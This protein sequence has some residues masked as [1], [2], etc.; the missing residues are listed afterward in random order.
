[1]LDQIVRTVGAA[2]SGNSTSLWGTIGGALLGGGG[3]IIGQQM[4]NEANARQSHDMI[5][6]QE[7]MSST[8]HQR[9]VADLKAAGLNPI[10]SA[11]GGASTPSGAQAQMENVLEGT[12]AS[13]IELANMKL[14][15][16]KQREEINLMEKEGKLTD[17]QRL[18]T[19][20][21]NEVIRKGIPEAELKNDLMDVIRPLLKK[22]KEAGSSGVQKFKKGMD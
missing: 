3:Q 6:F 21:E 5:A 17:A 18:K 15:A 9:E 8:A 19:H 1:M 22:M 16:E 20:T 10:L 11:N 4:A 14:A 13:A 2:G 12:A 7:R